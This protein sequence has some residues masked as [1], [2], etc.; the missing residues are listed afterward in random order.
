MVTR[1]CYKSES[2]LNE[3]KSVAIERLIKT[4][5][6]IYKFMTSIT[7]TLRIDN[8]DNIGNKYKNAYHRTIKVKPI[9]VKSS[10]YLDFSV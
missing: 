7:K 2:T 9:G 6:K 5:K 10:A 1:E 8:L 3:R 4:L